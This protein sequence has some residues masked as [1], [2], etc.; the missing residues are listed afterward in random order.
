M[1]VSISFHYINKAYV[2]GDCIQG[3]ISITTKRRAILTSLYFNIYGKTIT[4]PNINNSKPQKEYTQFFI[5]SNFP[6]LAEQ[7][8][9]SNGP[10]C[11]EY[12][13][14]VHV[15][16]FS[17]Q[18]PSVPSPSVTLK[19]GIGIKYFL[20][21]TL[22]VLTL[23]K[24]DSKTQLST[25][26]EES[27]IQIISF[28]KQTLEQNVT[29]KEEKT[30]SFGLFLK[31]SCNTSVVPNQPLKVTAFIKN[32]TGN[33][34]SPV[35]MWHSEHQY[36]ETYL[37]LNGGVRHLGDVETITEKEVTIDTS[38]LFP[39]ISQK[40]FSIRSFLEL[41]ISYSKSTIVCRLELNVGWEMVS[42][43]VNRA[44]GAL[45]GVEYISDKMAFYGAHMRP[46]PECDET[47]EKKVF[48]NKVY[49]VNHLL[50]KC[51]SD[52]KCL[53]ITNARY[54]LPECEKLPYGWGIG[55]DR[56]EIYFIN[57][58]KK[59]TTWIDPRPF[60]NRKVVVRNISVTLF[61]G[62]NFPALKGKVCTS[63]C[64]VFDSE[65]R[66]IQSG[67]STKCVDP[68][69]SENNTLTFSN[70]PDRE[71]FVLYFY[72]NKKFVGGIDLP[73]WRIADNGIMEWF[74]LRN[75]GDFEIPQTGEVLLKICWEGDTQPV[76][77]ECV[78][79]HFPPFYCNSPATK[80][81]E[82]YINKYRKKNKELPE[83]FKVSGDL[84]T[85]KNVFFLEV[86][87]S[88]NTFVLGHAVNYDANWVGKDL[89]KS[90]FLSSTD[91]QRR[92][93]RMASLSAASTPLKLN[94]TKTLLSLQRSTPL[95]RPQ[96]SLTGSLSRKAEDED[97][98][99]V[100]GALTDR[101]SVYLRNRN[102]SM[103]EKPCNLGDSP[104]MLVDDKSEEQ[105]APLSKEVFQEVVMDRE[106]ILSRRKRLLD[107]EKSKA[108]DELLHIEQTQ[109]SPRRNEL[110]RE[111][112]GI[113]SPRSP[114]ISPR[115]LQNSSSLSPRGGAHSPP[116]NTP[117]NI[118]VISCESQKL[119]SERCEK[120]V[121][122]LLKKS[123][124]DKSFE[125]HVA[126]LGVVDEVEFS[127]S[128][129]RLLGLV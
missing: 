29:F 97:L 128:E 67:S 102:N 115:S 52:S 82:K 87:I 113:L 47:V 110:K 23:K 68:I 120:R 26:S 88:E 95:H 117:R 124:S 49:Y 84:V 25:F 66:A 72:T 96:R 36:K 127:P 73:M 65:N 109:H 16:P 107:E 4:I 40:N 103:S 75:F 19:N 60:P 129:K 38:N 123:E 41:Q 90:P 59:Y 17:I 69:W 106:D 53:S 71:N 39:T 42:V 48:E 93:K 13:I 78:L 126:S 55:S 35:L 24:D 125:S 118:I 20:Q 50:R 5:S 18:V 74:Q 12:P 89:D 104:L 58:N 85:G 100:M 94:N 22:T 77:K 91:C 7:W 86:G 81:Q 34:V 92:E 83:E 33:L 116:N 27:E 9:S 46:T 108:M 121:S 105:F 15:V 51:Y 21:A 63:Y 79:A 99:E 80:D 62:R 70:S 111:S 44:R 61:K 43:D 114:V 45:L 8:N 6:P 14:G 122:S 101:Q 64:V 30:N 1:S 98:E 112:E 10:F 54:P 32:T 31:L 57:W 28:K 3:F 76:E 2:V 11:R 56:G 119:K 37:V